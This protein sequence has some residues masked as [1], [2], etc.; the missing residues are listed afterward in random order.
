M[1]ILFAADIR[2]ED[3]SMFEQIAKDEI[4]FAD[5]RSLTAEDM[6]EAEAV[7]GNIDPKLVMACPNLRWLQLDSAG[8]DRYAALEKDFI[9]TNASGAYGQAIAEHMLACTLSV[10]KKLPEY[11]QM[12]KMHGWENLGS[13]RTV[14]TLRVLTIGMG[15]IGTSYARLMH[16]LGAEVYGVRRTLQELP[17]AYAGQCTFAGMDEILP[18]CDVIAMSL[19]ETPET[20][21]IMSDARLRLTKPGSILLNVGRGSAIDEAALVRL[22]KNEHHFAGVCLDVFAHEP[23]PKNA[24]IRN[25]DGIWCTPHIAGRFNADATYHKVVRILAENLKHWVNEEPLTHTVSRTLGY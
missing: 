10:L 15:D 14:D 12:Q 9:L 16:L 25:T 5:R 6:K 23:L 24:E 19:P 7:I 21:G 22:Q 17:D 18:S 2:A 3:R 1:K 8:A 11:A 13:V 20:A 4:R